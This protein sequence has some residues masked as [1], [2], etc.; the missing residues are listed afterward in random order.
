MA[1]STNNHPIIEPGEARGGAGR[2]PENPCLLPTGWAAGK[3]ASHSGPSG[4]G[5]GAR[6]LPFR[7]PTPPPP[8]P[9]IPQG[10]PCAP[11]HGQVTLRLRVETDITW[12]GTPV[13]SGGSSKVPR[14]RAGWKAGRRPPPQLELHLWD[15]LPVWGIH[16]RLLLISVLSRIWGSQSSPPTRTPGSRRQ[17]LTQAPAAPATGARQDPKERQG[18]A[19]NEQ[20][21]RGLRQSSGSFG[22]REAG[23]LG[24][25]G[26]GVR[27]TLKPFQE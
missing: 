16:L 18:V 1:L 2:I 9:Q 5:K 20:N 24:R 7:P 22:G 8:R 3:P 26:G 27:A 19:V 4:Q 13:I 10:S 25:E 23:P 11:A 17:H 14:R 15:P 6:G 21:N 12:G